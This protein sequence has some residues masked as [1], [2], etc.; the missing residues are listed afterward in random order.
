MIK[1]ITL[2]LLLTM[3]QGLPPDQAVLVNAERAFAKLAVERGVRESFLTHFDDAAI[4]FNPH[5][6]VAKDRLR[7]N[8]VETL[9]LDYTLN[10][11]PTYGDISLAGDMGYNTGP[12]RVDRKT[13]A[14]TPPRH[15]VFFSVWKKRAEGDWKV[16]LDVGVDVPSAM[17]PLDAPFQPA[18]PIA[19]SVRYT[20]V[21]LEK[22]RASLLQLEKSLI[23]EGNAGSYLDES[24]RLNRPDVLPLAGK[25]AVEGWLASQGKRSGEPRF[26]DVAASGDLGY[27]YGDFE[28][29]GARSMKGYYAR[30]WRRD[31]ANRWKIVI[32]VLSPLPDQPTK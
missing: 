12:A 20:R 31:P 32:E 16:V 15:M 30:V 8:P 10:W 2:V 28:M 5:P 7:K 19:S 26:A 29:N 9:P 4:A 11:A 6:A 14:N 3:L 17:A 21:D 25:K 23:R 18:R 13:P 27:T 24:V 1:T 22:E